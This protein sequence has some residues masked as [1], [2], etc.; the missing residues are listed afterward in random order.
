MFHLYNSLHL[1]YVTQ[2]KF[3]KILQKDPWRN[4]S[5][6]KLYVT[7]RNLLKVDGTVIF[8]ELLVNVVNV[9]NIFLHF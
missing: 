9:V 4:T 8:S 2:R 1:F 6:Q 7:A 3:G 5:S